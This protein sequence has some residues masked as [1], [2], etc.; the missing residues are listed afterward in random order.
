MKIQETVLPNGLRV[1]AEINP[2]ARSVAMGYFVR[3]GS[4]DEAPAEQGLS[5]FLEHMVFKGTAQRDGLQVNR[6]FDQMGA[7]YNAMTSEE[8]TVYYGA[9]LPEFAP[10]LLELWTDLLRPALA[11]QDFFTEQQVILEEIAQYLDRPQAMLFDWARQHYY[12]DHPLGHSV[13]GSEAS[14]GALTPQVMRTYF[15]RRYTPSNMVLALAG[16]VDWDRLL[17]QV[18]AQTA[19]WLPGPAERQFTPAQPNWGQQLHPYPRASQVYL[20]LLAPGWSA[21]DE[22]RYEASVL[23]SILG[24]DSNSRLHWALVDSGLVES[25][26]A[27]HDE[28]DGTGTYSVYLQT[29]P[30]YAVQ[31]RDLLLSQLQNLHRGVSHDEVQ[32]AKARMATGL[33]FAAETPMSRLFNLGMSY[34]YQQ[35]YQS[36]A[37]VAQRVQAIT[38]QGVNAL[39]EDRPFDQ[40][41]LYAVVP[42][43]VE[44]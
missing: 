18:T 42:P 41:L 20:A 33:V 34:L 10:A 5:H 39:L 37:E 8:Y 24:D 14:I 26:G 28:A 27:S 21:Q 4:R 1:V 35:R 38:A 25:A 17:A 9:V 11:D 13:L 43:G 7:Q 23:A 22:R 16:Q 31:A 6:E 12:Q 30:R 44:V 19:V 36:L 32:R 40:H 2:Q 3:T 29:D 15:A